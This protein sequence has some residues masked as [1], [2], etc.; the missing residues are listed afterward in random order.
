MGHCNVEPPIT[1]QMSILSSQIILIDNWV[2]IGR[3]SDRCGDK[4]TGSI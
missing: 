3:I 4:L 1:V 2:K